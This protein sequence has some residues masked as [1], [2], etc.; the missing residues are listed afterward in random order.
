MKLQN[1]LTQVAVLS[2]QVFFQLLHLLLEFKAQQL[3]HTAAHARLRPLARIEQL[4]GD[5]S[6]RFHQR[7][8][9]RSASFPRG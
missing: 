6:L 8:E 1:S 5:F 7:R 2:R 3:P 9:N 4:D